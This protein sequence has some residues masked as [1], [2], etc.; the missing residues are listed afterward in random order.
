M[1]IILATDGSP[2]AEEAARFLSRLPHQQRMELTVLTT[3]FIPRVDGENATADWL[4]TFKQEQ[5]QAAREHCEHVAEM[6]AGA[7]VTLQ[8]RIAE[9]HVGH[10]ITEEAAAQDA[11]LIVLGARGHSAVDRILLGSVSD[12]VATEAKC[13][14]LVVRPPLQKPA[15]SL[16]ITIAYDDTTES[17]AALEQFAEFKWGEGVSGHLLT[18][19]PILRTY[20]HDLFPDTVFERS[21]QRADA[22]AAAQAAVDRIRRAAPRLEPDVIEAE[23]VG[24]A[25]VT[26]AQDHQSHLVVVGEHQRSALGR[27]MLGSVSRYVLR[28]AAGSVW[29]SR[30]KQS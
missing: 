30:G 11:D 26:Y 16:R 1:K 3:V 5:H 13:S 6:F 18:V 27:L 29:I 15:D 14:V 12:F 21:G 10:S 22:A 19:V 23:H 20:R 24:E 2:H 7:D 8:H 4:A 9:G 25:I 17:N 28:H